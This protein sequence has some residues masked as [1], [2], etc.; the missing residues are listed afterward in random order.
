MA[1][2]KRRE[3]WQVIGM[4]TL[5]LAISTVPY[6]MGYL[7]AGPRLEFGGFVVDLDDSF[8]YVAAMQQGIDGGWKYLVLFTPEDHPGAYLHTFYLALGKLSALLGL[9]LLK[10]YH[11]ARLACG[12]VLLVTAYF[13]SSLFLESRAERIV[14]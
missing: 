4:S 1:E 7:A 12:L 3:I 10:M 6:L 8:S 5:V 14:A 9:S 13:F 2:I 11:I